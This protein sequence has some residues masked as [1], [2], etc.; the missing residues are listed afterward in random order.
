MKTVKLSLATAAGLALAGAITTS[1]LAAPALRVP[2]AGGPDGTAAGL[3]STSAAVTMTRS[4][5]AI[6]GTWAVT[7]TPQAPIPRF[8]S[9]LS[10]LPGGEVVEVTS[11][12]PMSAGLG[13][14]RAGPGQRVITTFRKYRFNSAGDYIGQTTVR[15]V[16]TLR[17]DAGQ[18]TGQAT[19]TLT[20]PSGAV[21]SSFR[22]V[23]AGVRMPR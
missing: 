17:N 11:K 5:D 12:G 8:G 22:S 21:V 16:E 15:E 19:T 3:A 2:A 14:W 6:T 18:Y 13:V 20:S 23:S 4:P 10:F 9:T 1:A 7:V